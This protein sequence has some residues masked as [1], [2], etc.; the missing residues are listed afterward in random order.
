MWHLDADKH[1][2]KNIPKILANVEDQ[3]FFSE[4][5]NLLASNLGYLIIYAITMLVIET[6][7]KLAVRNAVNDSVN[8]L[9]HANLKHISQKDYEHNILSIVHHS[10]NVTSA[11]KNLF[12]EFPRKIVACHHFLL[13]LKELSRDI[14][15]YSTMVNIVFVLII[16]VICF[17]RKYLISKI[18]DLNI[19]FN[20]ECS[21]IAHSIQ[22][23]K[24]D[25]R[26]DECHQRIKKLTSNIWV[27]SSTD[28]LMV[29]CHE[30]VT[31]FS[32]QF[33]V[34]FISYLCRPMVLSRAIAIEDLLYG[35]T[36]SS[37]FIEKMIG[38]FEYAGDVIRQYK[39]FAFFIGISKA[40]ILEPEVPKENF[41]QLKISTKKKTTHLQLDSGNFVH[42]VGPNGVGK[43]TLLLNFLG[44]AYSGATSKGACTA[45]AKSGLC[46]DPMSYRNDIAFVQ[47]NIPSTHETVRQYIKSVVGNY[48]NIPIKFHG[49]TIG[50]YADEIIDSIGKNKLMKELSGGQAKF[51]QILAAVLKLW[52]NNGSV[53]VLDEPSNNLDAHRVEL[54]KELIRVCLNQNITVLIVTHDNRIVGKKC[55]AIEL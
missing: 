50:N 18:V 20:I 4:I 5:T 10:E 2:I 16:L 30:S 36:A 19:N 33:M 51:V 6:I 55:L 3:A 43:T 52:K 41:S 45:L 27:H 47:Q 8:K 37:K 28:S 25:N 34:G 22:S 26:L 23:H 40:T 53:L 39:S 35:I 48:D 32:G 11:I 24:V 54:L 42:F 1:L 21:D 44:V 29:A 9:L 17:V 46:V 38:I 14:M 12:I 31:S 7:G 15:I 49:A 13:A